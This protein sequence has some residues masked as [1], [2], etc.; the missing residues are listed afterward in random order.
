MDKVEEFNEDDVVECGMYYVE[1]RNY[2]P[3]R[4]NGW[5]MHN[6]IK[7]CLSN[8]LIEVEDIKYKILPSMKLQHDFFKSFITNVVE[9]FGP[10]FNKL[11]PN[12]FIGC[13]NK[14]K[15]ER[16]TMTMTTSNTQALY[17]FYN[18]NEAFPKYDNELK[19]WTMT[20]KKQL[21]TMSHACQFI[22]LSLNKKSSNYINYQN[23]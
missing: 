6:T 18:N 20:N 23:K 15:S 11:G 22:N 10:Q 4:G 21:N 8:F 9:K 14:T 16:T 17:E 12:A 2:M 13:M 19:L 5:Y 7:Y 1:S 3:L